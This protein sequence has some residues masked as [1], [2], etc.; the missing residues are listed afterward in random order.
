MSN[1]IDQRIVEMSFENHKFEKGIHQSKNSLKE[2]SNALQN[3]GTGKD[4]T[5]LENSVQSIGSSFSMLEQIGI[6]ALRRIGEAALGA[7]AQLVK[8]LAFDPIAQGMT[9]YEQKTA[10]VQTI[11]NATGKSIEEVNGYLNQLMWFS[12][13][14]SYSF[15]DM[16]AALAQ[17]TSS[18]GDIDSLIPLIT[19]VA[20][21]TAYAGKGA[22][23]FSRS[24]YN[25]NQ[26]YGRGNLEYIDWRSLE[27]AGV[28]GKDLKQVFIDTAKAMGVLDAQ[29]R[30]VKG[31][32]VTVGNFASTL[33]E[34][35]ANTAVMEQAFGKFSELSQE[36][37]KLV[38]DGTFETA[39]EA[40]E[41]LSGKYSEIAEKGFKSA[42]QAK[43]FGEAINATLD[44]VSSGWM[45]TYEVIFGDLHEATRN[46][47][48]LTEILWTIFASGAASRNEILQAIKDAGGVKSAFQSIKNIAVALIKP[49]K[50]ISQA[51]DQFF[52]PRTA[53]Q[54][55]SIITM[56]ETI[57][58][59]FIITDETAKKIQRTFAG[60]FAVVDLGWQTV[61]FLGSALYEVIDA[62]IPLGGNLLEMT[63]TV[64]DFLVMMNQLVKQSGVF[65]Y[66]LLGVKVAAVLLKNTLTNIIGTIS[67]FI[68][69]LWSTD[70]PLEFIGKTILKVFSGVLNT[71]KSG[72]TWLSGKFTGALNGVQK[73]LNT[74]INI[75]SEG[76]LGGIFTM[77]KD[78][79][80]FLVGE[81]TDGITNFGKAFD[82]L[83]LNR[84]TTFITGGVLLLFINQLSNL[85]N[86]MATLLTTTNSFVSKFSKKLFGTTTKIK[87]LA[88]VFGVLSASLFVL[89]QVPW[90]KMKV[91]MAG[92]AFALGLF[93]TAYGSMQLIT[94]KASKALNGIEV[95]KAS[96]SLGTLAAGVAGMAFALKQI[97]AIS[98]YDVWRSVGVLYA[99]VGLV[100]A[101]QAISSLI[102]FIPVKNK[103]VADFKGLAA[104]IAAL[105]GA[106]V[107][108]QFM[109]TETIRSGI[110]KLVGIVAILST[111]QF[112][113]AVAAKVG[114]GNKLSNSLLGLSLGILGLIG[115]LKLLSVLDISQMTKAI[116][117]VLLIGGVLG[118][119]QILFSVAAR[120]GGGNKFRANI[121]SMTIGLGA[122]VALIAIMD[123]V[124][125]DKIQNGIANLFKLGGIIVGIELLTAL[126]A[127]IGGGHK[128]QKILGSVSLTMFAFTA[129]IAVISIMT[130]ETIDKGLAT[131]N[132]MMWIIFG[133]QTLISLTNAIIGPAST[134]FGVITG[135][136]AGVLTVAASLI[137]LSM[138]DQTALANSAKV[139]SMTVAA[140]GLMATGLGFMMKNMSGLSTGF[141][142]LKMVVSTLIPGFVAMGA[143][144]IATLALVELINMSNVGDVS[145][146]S[147]GKFTVGLTV[148]TGL[149]TAFS[150]LAKVPGLMS[151]GAG[152]LTLIPGFAGMA[153]VVVATAG[154]FIAINSVLGIVETVSWASFGKF[155]AGLALIG[156]M[157]M[158]ISLLSV[159]LAAMGPLILPILGGVLAAVAGVGI[160]VLA[161]A[162][163][164]AAFE[165]FFGADP[166]FLTR[167]IEKLVQMGEGIGR[168][169][170][171]MAGGLSS[172]LLISYGEG[173]AGFADV[174]SRINPQSFAGVGE[175]AGAI[176]MLTGASMLDGLARFV[177]SGRNPGE[178]F[179]AQIQGLIKAFKGIE[180]EDAIKT[181]N[182]LSALG[183][184]LGNLES[185]IGIST[186]IPNEG[187]I[188]AL[189]IG[190]N[191]ID[192]FA[193]GV[194]KFIEQ[195]NK[196]DLFQANHVANIFYALGPMLDNF[197]KLIGATNKIPNEGGIVAWFTGNNN[198]D[199][200]GREIKKFIEY[201]DKIDL[202]QANHVGNIFRA[203]GPMLENFGA[204]IGVAATIPNEGGALAWFVGNNNI[205]YFAKGIVKMIDEFGKIDTSKVSTVSDSL[206]LMASDM[207]PSIT[208]F[209]QLTSDLTSIG[210]GWEQSLPLLN[211]AT[212]LKEFINILSGVDASIVAPALKSLEDINESFKVIGA[213]VLE[214]AKQ[215]FENNKAPFQ[216]SIVT[217]LD[218]IIKEVDGRKQGITNSF[219]TIF[220]E[221]LKKSK[222]YITE[223]K[224]LGSDIVKGLKSGIDE[225]RPSALRA[226]DTMVSKV[227]GR[228]EKGFVIASPSKVFAEIGK[229][230]PAGLGYGIERN[231]KV[232]ILAAANMGYAVEESVRDS[233]DIH[234]LGDKF[235]GIGKWI[236]PGLSVGIESTKG[237]LLDTAKS[238]GLDTTDLTIKGMAE[239]LANGEGAVTKTFNDLLDIL[240]G[241]PTVSDMVNAGSKSGGAFAGGVA[242]GIGSTSSKK[243]VA[244]SAAEL[245]NDAYEA[246]VKKMNSLTDYGLITPE[247][248]ISKWEEFTNA[249]V[250]GTEVRL[251]AEKKLNELRFQYSKN[252]IDREKYYK[253]LSL[254][255]E[256]AAWERVQARYKEGHQYRL[257]A[258]REIFRVKQEIAQLDYQ[259]A[260]DAIDDAKYYGK[261]NLTEELKAWK[262][263]IAITE[264]A[265]DE[266]KKANREIYRLENEIRD[267]NLAYEEKLRKIESDRND[268]RIQLEEEY[269]DKV[270]EIN[271]R[272]ERDIQS[273]NDAYEN[274]VKSRA[275]TLYSTWGLFDKVDPFEPI[276]PNSLFKNLEDQVVAFDQW[277]AQIGNLAAKGIDEGLIEELRAMG[278]KSLPQILALN[279]MT[280]TQLNGYVALWRKKSSEA[281]DQAVF[282]LQD[283]K[284]ETA[285]KIQ[286]LTDE[287]D[288]ELRYY[289]RVWKDALRDLNKET[290]RQLEELEED[291]VN[292]LGGMT[293]TGIDLIKQFRLE[294]FNEIYEIVSETRDQMAEL[295]RLTSGSRA[296]D[297]AAEAVTSSLRKMDI[298]SVG[299]DAVIGFSG[300]VLGAVGVAAKA[301]TGLMTTFLGANRKTLDSHSPSRK[302]EELGEFSVIGFVKGLKNLSNLVYAEG[303]SVGRTAL[304]AVSLSMD[305]IPDL[306]GPDMDSFTITPVLDLTNVKSGMYDV[307]SMLNSASGLDLS[308]TMGLLPP[309]NT[310]NQNGMLLAELRD[311]LLNITNQEVDLSGTLTVQVVNDRGEIIDIAETAIKDLLRRESR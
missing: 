237:K 241:N 132:R 122:M 44:A 302:M 149:V 62:F 86:S 210:N 34:K 85:T 220:D 222:S 180:Y 15:T 26:S 55:T 213:E 43:S 134:G 214:S 84:L 176:L 288:E 206:Q 119:I 245:A 234:S 42:Q 197:G 144:V 56:L 95:V 36:A 277:Q 202:F 158:G 199:E 258:E 175:L 253:R 104:G 306:L 75:D 304:E 80:G 51:F 259:N 73:V 171:A 114:G 232:A 246:F 67:E 83:N 106:L 218:G 25:L 252:W 94:V 204:F 231:S 284:E 148:L 98:E 271:D 229:W 108:L 211:F 32:L 280:D 200:F 236:P 166:N 78:F 255:E 142:G 4:F 124:G 139:L 17:M 261:M 147:F 140:V 217:F 153:L 167:G 137:L 64:G 135:L 54:W 156:V 101:Y 240:T 184:M 228:T 103:L 79:I 110:S 24:M 286:E 69:T 59:R 29:G 174:M 208:K 154:L 194:K 16:T 131:I 8:N 3:M 107:V 117:N 120:I 278:P 192:E 307:N 224:T 257:Q 99:I 125:Q 126:A 182:I 70:K 46:F 68:T 243:K 53:A 291:W 230:L 6:G 160:V 170:G 65:Q 298:S 20:N 115:V 113:F 251:K 287:A 282:E 63:A 248:E 292:N 97:S 81:A 19:G 290:R 146:D 272:L 299:R 262:K 88:F 279:K 225:G 61:K 300:G 72:V 189:F 274:A 37:Y 150:M 74:K 76:T 163:L 129:L 161:F 193:K 48:A 128:L 133:F 283:M 275:D 22:A 168:F 60:F 91:G 296:L 89:S 238:L 38:N 301:G 7:G 239:G 172:E 130:P 157:A 190:D 266:R 267:A 209:V 268:K 188:L 77:L 297:S 260:V 138:Q 294:W 196:V 212:T 152:I 179:G 143:I 87:D 127:R 226:I 41:F 276:D 264:E 219:S 1:K 178:V 2:F 207:L 235:P 9:K 111:I 187:G 14:T 270:K 159:P 10:S 173:L 254:A 136:V 27:L 21:A 169:I 116:G 177:N 145:W 165:A 13:E 185:L 30:T 295:K 96:L 203:L 33:S 310:G 49:L 45:R 123:K 265:S 35:W 92:L 12:D 223:F 28:A 151:G 249:Q 102:S 256:L 285:I 181:A 58:K 155:I 308:A 141:A 250:E 82:S 183:P 269:Y 109:N 289:K 198:I 112:V 216:T 201:F 90:D 164:A 118:A 215:S 100:A 40:I 244:K 23:E 47:T 121:F 309:G 305:A 247:E 5:G 263:I 281:K 191:T 93:V 71:L 66:G 233:L 205:D 11:M 273:L 57:T 105:V 293:D 227:T 242:D 221:A 311:A 195:F 52:P 186:N 39:A 50:A 18:G 162:G 31:T 303:A